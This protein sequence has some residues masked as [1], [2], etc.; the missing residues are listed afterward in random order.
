MKKRLLALSVLA[1][2]MVL[3]LA[4]CGDPIGDW[5]EQ[6]QPDPPVVEKQEFAVYFIAGEGVGVPSQTV[7]E[8][9]LVTKPEDPYKEGYLFENWY[10]DSEHTEV[11]N[12]DSDTV[13][14]NTIIY[15]KWNEH[16]HTGGT[17][18]CTEKA[19]CEVCGH[20]YGTVLPHTGGEATCTSPAE[21]EVCGTPYGQPLGHDVVTL[22]GKAPTCTETGLTEGAYCTRCD[23]KVEQEVIPA[24][25]HTPVVDEAV[26]P[27]CTETGLTEGSHCSVCDEVLVAQEVVDALGHTFGEWIVDVEPTIEA[28]GSKHRECAC[29]EIETETIPALD[30]THSYTPEV[31]TEAGCETDGVRTFTCS[32]GDSYTEVIPATGHTKGEVVVENEVAATCTAEGSHDN[33]VYCVE[34]DKELSR[35]TVTTDA[36]GHKDEN[37]DFKCDACSEVLLPEADSTLTIEEAEA[38]ANLF[39]HN[40]Y[41]TNKYYVTCEIKNVYNTQY[42]NINIV[43]SDFVIYGLYS[44]DG[45][46]RYDAMSYKPTVSDK[47]TVYG[48]IGKYNSTLQMKNG[49]LVDLVA[50]E[51][52]FS[53][54]TCEA[55]ATCSICGTTTGELADHNYVDGTC[56]VCGKVEGAVV[57]EI[58]FELGAN[59]KAEHSD[60]TDTN[61]DKTYT[62]TLDGY[63]LT[64]TSTAKM[65]T[66]ARDNKGNSCLKFG[67]SSKTGNMSFTVP[68]DVVKV[69]IYV[70]GYKATTTTNIKVNGT[71]YTV[72]TASN[73]GEYTAIEIDTTTTK[74]VTFETVTYRAMIN[75]I[76]FTLGATE[77]EC[78]HEGGKATCKELAVC[79]KCGE[80]YGELGGHT[81]VVDSPVAPTCEGTGLTEGKHCSVCNEVLVAQETV[82]ALGHNG[83]EA[84]VE[85]DVKPTCT[86]AGSYDTVV[87]CT[88]CEKEL[89]RKTTTVNAL[90]HA[91]G[92]WI[93]DAPAT[94]E[95]DGTK[96]RVCGTC[97]EV[98]E[99]VIPSIEHVHSY[100]PT[101]TDPTCTEQGYTTHTCR[102][103]V[104]YVDTYVDALG[105]TAGEAT[106]E[107]NVDPTCTAAG[108]Y[109][110]VVYC[111]VCEVELSRTTVP[112]DALGHD[113]DEVVTDPT[114]TAKGYTTHTCSVC[115]DTYTDNEVDALGHK[116]ENHDFKCDACSTK[117]LPE[118]DST[119][120]LAEAVAIGKLFT[121][122]TYTTEKYYITCTIVSVYNTQYGNM[123]VID[124][125]G[126]KFVVYGLYTWNKAVRYD[127][128][129]YKPVAGDEI[130]VYGVI[131]QYSGTPQMKDAWLDEVVAHEHEWDKEATCTT[132]ATC[133]IC[134]AINTVPHTPSE[135]ELTCSTPIV[136]TVCEKVLETADHVDENE[137]GKCDLCKATLEV[138]AEDQEIVFQLGANGSASHSDGTDST[139][140]TKYTETVDGITLTVTSTQSMYNGARD[141]KGN[142]CLKFGTSKKVGNM[143]FTVP[144]NVTKVIIYVAGYK[145]TT[146][147]NIK[148]NG[149][150]Y[151]VKTASDKGEYTAIEVD[152]A[153]NKKVEFVTVTYRAMVNSI[154]FVVPGT[155]GVAHEHN[156]ATREENRVEPTCAVAGSYEKVTYCAD[157]DCGEVLKRETFTLDRVCE[158]ACEECGKCTD[159]E[160]TEDVCAEKC[161]CNRV[162]FSTT[163]TI[164][165]SKTGVHFEG[166][167]GVYEGL[168]IDATNGKFADNN[169]GWVQVN[170]GTVITLYVLDGAQVS[171]AAYS[172]SANFTVEVVDGVCT[173]TAVG[174]DYLKAVT[175][176]YVIVYNEETTIDLSKTGVHF[177][178]NTGVYE[179]LE[180][181]ATNGKF[182]DNNGGWV[183]VN[184]GTIITFNVFEGANVSVKAYTSADNFTITVVDGVCT[185]TAVGNDYINTITIAE[186]CNCA[187]GNSDH[188]CDACGETLSQCADVDPRDHECDVCGLAL[189]RCED[190]EIK[191]HVCEICGDKIS[192]CADD[193][194]D[195]NCDVCGAVLSE[196]DTDYRTHNC[197]Y[198]GKKLTECL[199]LDSDHE[200]DICGLA[201]S[202]CVDANNNHKC[203]IC[204]D[205]M[206]DCADEDHNHYCDICGIQNSQCMDLPPY[207][208]NC[209]WC[210]EKVSDCEGGTATCKDKAVCKICGQPYGELANHDYKP[211]VT[212]PDCENRGYTTYTCSVCED[213]YVVDYTDALGHDLE[214]HDAKTPTYS[215]A[216][217]EAYESCKREGCGYSTKVELA[218]VVYLEPSAEWVQNGARF[219]IYFFGGNGTPW[220]DMSDEDGDGV[221]EA[222]IIYGHTNL[223][224]VCMS[225]NTANN[226]DNKVAQ[227][228]DLSLSD[229]GN[230]Y[231]VVGNAGRWY[232]YPCAHEYSEVTCTEDAVCGICGHI[233]TVA[234]GHTWAE[235]VWTVVT[236]PTTEADGVKSRECSVCGTVTDAILRQAEVK[237]M[238]YLTPN[239]NWKVDNARFAAYFFGNGEK[240]VSMTY[241]SELKVYEVEVPAG[242]PNV[243][244]CRM[245][246][247]TTANNWTNKWNQTADLKVPVDGTNHYT[248]KAGTWDNG[249]GAWTTVTVTVE[250][251]HVYY[252]ATCTTVQTC[253][254]CD[255]TY[256]ELGEHNYGEWI[257]AVPSTCKA[258]GTLGHYACS[259]CEKNFDINKNELESLI[260]DIDPDAH[261]DGEDENSN[262]DYCQAS[263]CTEHTWNDGEVVTE[264][265]CVTEGSEKFTCT[266]C[267]T[268]EIR[269]VNPLGHD[270]SA[271]WTVDVSA[272]CTEA[273]SKSHHCSR[274]DSK[275]DVTEIPATGHRYGNLVVNSASCTVDGYIEITCGNCNV[276]FD[277]REDDEAKQYLISFPFINVTAKGHT[278]GEMVT[279]NVT[280]PDCVNNGSHDEVF[281]CTV[282]EAE[283]SRTTVTDK[284]LGHKYDSVVTDPNCV[285][286]GYT[287]HTCDCGHSYVD[288]Y[289]DALKHIDE[290]DD[291]ICDRENC[292]FILCTDEDHISDGGVVTTPAT[293]VA[294]G[295]RTYS[296]SAC[297]KEL[298]T[299]EIPVDPNAHNIVEMPSKPMTCTEDG[300]SVYDACTLCDY[301]DGKNIIKSPGHFFK[302]D[303]AA[304]AATCTEDGYTATERCL[305]CDYTKG[306]E[307]IPA[308]G[309][310]Y[311][312][313]V[314]D[315][316]CTE[317]GY[318]THTCENCNHSYVDTTVSATG[319]NIVTDKAV[320]PTCTETGLTEGS[321]CSVCDEVFVAQDVVDAL[322][323]DEYDLEEKAATCEEDGSEGGTGCHTCG[324]IVVAP[325]V[326]TALGHKHTNGNVICDNCGLEKQESWTLV[327]NVSQLVA[328]GKV[329]IVANGYNYAMS[330][331]QNG[332]NR[333]QAAVTKSSDKS[334]VTFGSDVQIFTL[335][336][337][338]TSGTF[339]F[340]TGSG[341]IYA[342]SSSSNYLRTETS[343][344]N[345]SSWTIT[346][347]SAG[348][349]TVKSAGTYT[350]NWLRYNSSNNPPIFSCYGSGQADIA[351]YV[352]TEKYVEHVHTEKTLSAKAPTCENTGL[353]EGKQCTVC[354]EVTVAQ[355][356][357][358]ATGHNYVIDTAVAPTCQDTGLTEGTHC[359]NGCGIGTVAQVEVPV[360]ECNFVNGVCTMCGVS[361]SHVCSPAE[362]V[363]E[364]RV[365][366]T[367]TKDGSYDMVVYCEGCGEE[368]ERETFTIKSEGH[369]YVNDVCTKCKE[370]DPS[371]VKTLQKASSIAVGDQIVIVCESKKMEFTSVS[372]TKGINTAYTTA[373]AGTWV[374]TVVEGSASGTFALKTSD[375]KYVSWSS[376]NSIT[377]ATSIT[378]NSSWKITFSS[379]NATIANAKDNTRKLQYNASSPR[380]C[381]YTSS[382]TAVQIYKFA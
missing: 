167:T 49:W 334:S 193:N 14:K 4:S 208:H 347:T 209:D 340:Y 303:I 338:K 30:H 153:T 258:T 227:T 75:S 82:D 176:K 290:N 16:T 104:S 327:T 339:A 239:S 59:G 223:I 189:T 252:P 183:Q 70:S 121:S 248:V 20:A 152:T 328:G 92:E 107:N 263:L 249:G 29:G 377:T 48:V 137:N 134:G 364:N 147:T 342:A 15:A 43:G 116:D 130:T 144:E 333:A 24:L 241:N 149:T 68:D 98:E 64:I 253:Y 260:I 178:G 316:T 25:G 35:E 204:N 99:G 188:K 279:E 135:N 41:T 180:I 277:S 359:A 199:D 173:I 40:T 272:T 233:G 198:C 275:S 304:K 286:K 291:N 232:N 196:C 150:Q 230:C 330:T 110:N 27:T 18:T 141:A 297:G 218:Y 111:T 90:G 94:E 349:A 210:G 281:Y 381:C 51:H 123:N 117:M 73:N 282:C 307:T 182:A 351:L 257:V 125:N 365:E 190:G 81:E 211:V 128:M 205:K 247:G 83:G 7:E 288:T 326:I 124:E 217:W 56:S 323:H 5:L 45:K 77:P 222:E 133:K 156:E 33:V 374:L 166:N 69:V 261:F 47:I 108:S 313:V 118:A 299:E 23:A 203:D 26:A 34:C 207:D 186:K 243:I 215:E 246:P 220:V 21:C 129:S 87:Y 113:Y 280:A 202:E 145:A 314:T 352:A 97:G 348:V 284:A 53:E 335:Q 265:T 234:S 19:I 154:V 231:R 214:N 201:I 54:A 126:T 192:N 221:Y 89:S 138:A 31:T 322:G 344:S 105:H 318:T 95:A 224:F 357:I 158:S 295:V 369:N 226:W 251:E 354:G 317:E 237:P 219:A 360:I 269:T 163:T 164:D 345:N 62:E 331:T 159:T 112:V 76:V 93:E 216:G 293:C 65:Y 274:C 191:N 372:G 3:A 305:V 250:H 66:G 103:G 273:G 379:G 240:W 289:V 276:T 67:T 60:G 148:V 71:A 206:S 378:A 308:L 169:G 300:H 157:A 285:D 259:V 353:T 132:S 367:C 375:G 52:D 142:S 346:V 267:G 287:T 12:F 341:Y 319:H 368:M 22:E 168:E 298:R 376:G 38:I 238:L 155:A 262:C 131:G 212:A 200:C 10:K 266:A 122:N 61:E 343:L 366:A 146:S 151:T 101:V 80:S 256:G 72:K 370:K 55:L 245:N 361:E 2:V 139:A 136:C 321:H 78:E 170:T 79:D 13:T 50:H 42:G 325:S 242:Y 36:L 143:S 187:D 1:L 174:N 312:S 358:P 161:I 171:V 140:D 329:V 85:K 84:V 213:S 382:Q 309:H 296:C 58:R 185:I 270:Y 9:G 119:L 336:T 235:E 311:K 179:G 28:A 8:G 320:A 380:F 74:T 255:A 332:N 127:A 356:E 268:T 315:P 63:T 109:E 254:Q 283:L 310:K 6:F 324:E 362:A 162:V 175:V 373:P 278:A 236:A 225:S 17:A 86:T 355:T 32:C 292:E 371:A 120:T 88:V 165:L 197:E 11:W 271:E 301:E 160:C 363:E 302:I 294:A 337:G 350:R 39:A 244:F 195:H 264:A 184:T 229:A 102:C 194:K 114:C 91:W 46:I 172:N 44:A 100:T 96:H 37:G 177:E 181:D 228:A 306:N 57:T 115:G 106:V